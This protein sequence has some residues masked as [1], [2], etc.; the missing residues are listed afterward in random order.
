VLPYIDMPVQHGSEHVLRLMRRGGS[1]KR[2]TSIIASLKAN[3]PHLVL[4]TTV[5][6]GFPGETDDDFRQLYDFVEENQFD[7]MGVFQYSNEENTKAYD[8]TDQVAAEVKEDRFHKI[9]ALQR[10][11]SAKKMRA[12]IGSEHE[13]VVEG[14]SEEHDYL[15]KGRLWSQ[16]P[17]IDG[18]TYIA[19][20]EP[21]AV[22]QMVKLTITDA[23]DYD[24]SGEVVA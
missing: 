4:R 21:L 12:L 1:K 20:P 7:R 24:L 11:I 6:V 10:E 15:V 14:Q 2:L 13:A 8:F 3:I 19:S 17:D 23:H 18:L 5:M 16:A 22:G 9:M